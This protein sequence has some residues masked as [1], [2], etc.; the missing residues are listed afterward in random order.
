MELEQLFKKGYKFIQ[1]HITYT[2]HMRPMVNYLINQNYNGGLVGCEIGVASGNNALSMLRNLPIKKLYLVDPY[3]HYD[4]YS[5]Y[6]MDD[7][8]KRVNYRLKEYKNKI[9]WLKKKSEEI[10]DDIDICSLDFIYIDGN[11]DYNFVN[12]DIR[13]AWEKT[14]KGGIIGGHDFEL[15]NIGVVR[16]VLEFADEKKLPIKG[17]Y[18]DWWFIKNE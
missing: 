4:G 12:K 7:L 15:R 18:T 6:D 17:F 8:R 5:L 9:I 1:R 11:H 16:A 2:H 13:M 14:K 10:A 3:I